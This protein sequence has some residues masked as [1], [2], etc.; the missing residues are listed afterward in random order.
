MG[1]RIDHRHIIARQQRQVVI[2]FHVGRF[3]QI[4][5]ARINDDQLRPGPNPLFQATAKNRMGIGGVGPNDQ[6]NIRVHHTVEGLG[7]RRGA[8]SLVEA[9][10]GG[11]V[12]NPGAGIHI[13]IAERRADHFLHHIDLFIGAS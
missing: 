7:A 11:A 13:V 3:N 8:Q 1:Q 9:I 2:G 4:N 12:T 10:S 5:G 6:N